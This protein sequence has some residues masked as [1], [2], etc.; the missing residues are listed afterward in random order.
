M[1]A[2]TVVG[3]HQVAQFV[4]HLVKDEVDV[5]V[6]V[7]VCVGTWT[8]QS[9]GVRLVGG[10]VRW[11]AVVRQHHVVRAR[12]VAGRCVA[13]I[14]EIVVF[15]A[16]D[17]TCDWL[18]LGQRGSIHARAGLCRWKPYLVG[19]GEEPVKGVVAIRVGDCRADRVV[20]RPVEL[21]QSHQHAGNLFARVSGAISVCI[22][23][24]GGTETQEAKPHGFSVLIVLVGGVH[25]IHGGVVN[26]IV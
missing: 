6:R 17:G 1:V 20:H 12:Q 3:P 8:C 4:G 21:Q 19:T 15:R 14:V 10:V 25:A 23:V 22:F 7:C 26:V 11:L 9:V 18:P 16:R 24:D 13:V 5:E 2:C